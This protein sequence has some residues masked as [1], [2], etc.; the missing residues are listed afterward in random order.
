M[1]H[2]LRAI[3][4]SQTLRGA[5]IGSFKAARLGGVSLNAAGLAG[6]ALDQHGDVD[7][8]LCALKDLRAEMRIGREDMPLSEDEWDLVGACVY[9]RKVR[10]EELGERRR[11]SISDEDSR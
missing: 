5:L 3:V 9:V 2:A 11:P 1:S 4:A 8:A 6:R 7:G 10:E